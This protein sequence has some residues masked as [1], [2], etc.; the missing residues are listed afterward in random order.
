ML[1]LKPDEISESLS[2]GVNEKDSTRNLVGI[3]P[4]YTTDGAP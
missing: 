2:P 1:G 3:E 4:V